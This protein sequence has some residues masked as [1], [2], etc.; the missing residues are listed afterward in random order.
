MPQREPVTWDYQPPA[1]PEDSDLPRHARD[2]REWLDVLQ[3]I[4]EE[5]NEE[6][7]E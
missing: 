7:E 5:E 4:R 6:E 3:R 2:E 1:E